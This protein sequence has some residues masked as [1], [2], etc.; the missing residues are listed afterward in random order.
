M[1]PWLFIIILFINGCPNQTY[2]NYD[3]YAENIDYSCEIDEDCEIKDVRNC[4][5]Y[6]PKCVNTNFEPDPDFVN[7]ICEKE[8]LVEICGFPEINQCI[9]VNKKCEPGWWNISSKLVEICIGVIAGG[10]LSVIVY[11]TATKLLDGN[12]GENKA[13]VGAIGSGLTA[14]V[15]VYCYAR[16]GKDKY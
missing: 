13:L 1:K 2:S 10:G 8:E 3:E 16:S 12:F 9:C 14:L 7:N 11:S 15:G 4:C 5:G 6:Y